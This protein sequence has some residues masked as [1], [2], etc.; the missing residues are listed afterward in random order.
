[1]DVVRAAA[2]GKISREELR[3]SSNLG[4]T[5]RSTRRLAWRTTGKTGQNP[6]RGT[7]DVAAPYFRDERWKT[8]RSWRVSA[9]D[10]PARALCLAFHPVRDRPA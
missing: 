6:V 2:H 1:M 4:S 3:E 7:L 5:S 8:A 9:A 10:T